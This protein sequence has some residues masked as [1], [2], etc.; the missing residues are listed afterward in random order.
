MNEYRFGDL[1][2]GQEEKFQR[3]ITSDMLDAFQRL[4]GDINPLHSDASYAKERGYKD[5]VVYG[6]LTASLISTLGGVYLPG[7][8]CLIQSV[9]VKFAKPVFAG[10]VLTVKGTITELHE[11]VNQLVLKVT[12]TNQVQI[13]VCRGTLKAGVLDE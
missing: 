7:K 2:I 11:N 5:R 4:S 9:E 6:M 3:E 1:W 8:F 10:D 12:I 13:K